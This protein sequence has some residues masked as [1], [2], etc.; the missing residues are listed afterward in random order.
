MPCLVLY[1]QETNIK[2]RDDIA[3]EPIEDLLDGFEHLQ[4]SQEFGVEH[5][6][7]Q[8]QKIEVTVLMYIVQ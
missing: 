5:L 4:E 3:D 8:L 6:Q 2:C 1:T 7:M